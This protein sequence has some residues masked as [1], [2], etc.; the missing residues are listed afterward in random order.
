MTDEAAAA[1]VAAIKFA[2]WGKATQLRFGKDG[3][4]L[5]YRKDGV[6]CLLDLATSNKPFGD[7]LDVWIA[8]PK[9]AALAEAFA[10]PAMQVIVFSCGTIA[11]RQSGRPEL[12]T[13]NTI[14]K[15]K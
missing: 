3:A 4:R 2:V 15:T 6:V 14:G 9:L 12:K 1:E 13:I 5:L 10:V 8:T 7:T 11:Y